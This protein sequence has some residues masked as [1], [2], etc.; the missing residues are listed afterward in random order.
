MNLL[1]DTHVL[2]WWVFDEPRLSASARDAVADSDNRVFVSSASGWEIATKQRIGKLPGYEGM[3][4]A[5]PR[6]L[7]R[8]DFDELPIRLDHALRAGSLPG[9]HRD[10]FDRILIAQAQVEGLAVMTADPV[11][12]RYGATVIW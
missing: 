11:F 12:A 7:R 2:L 10:P 1:L 9:P 6:L 4:Q 8:A 5:L 3:V